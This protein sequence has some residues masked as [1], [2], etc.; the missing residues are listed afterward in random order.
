MAAGEAAL[1]V[2]MV[3]SAFDG[4]SS[5]VVQ[6]EIMNM[7]YFMSATLMYNGSLPKNDMTPSRNG[8]NCDVWNA[9]NGQVNTGSNKQTILDGLKNAE[10]EYKFNP[11]TGKMEPYMKQYKL[12]DDYKV[13]LRCTI[14]K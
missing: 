9:S 4:D 14:V 3:V 6:Y 10:I 13:L 7:L 1:F 12:N 2:M 11:N 8:W 5:S